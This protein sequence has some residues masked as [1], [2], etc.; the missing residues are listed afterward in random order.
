MYCSEGAG[1][2]GF[3]VTASIVVSDSLSSNN[4]FYFKDNLTLTD[5]LQISKD[6]AYVQ[7]FNFSD[8]PQFKLL[9]VYL[10]GTYKNLD[11]SKT[12]KLDAV[13]FYNKTTKSSGIVAGETKEK[14]IDYI[15]KNK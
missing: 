9:Y 5:E 2:T 13:Y 12:Y 11:R 6:A 3:D 14:I 4:L 1:S 8:Q 15:N 10:N 7:H